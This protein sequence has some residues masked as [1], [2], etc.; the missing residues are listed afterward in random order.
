MESDFE[1]AAPLL[2]IDNSIITLIIISEEVDMFKYHIIF[3]IFSIVTLCDPVYARRLDPKINESIMWFDSLNVR[4]VSNWP[5]GPSRAVACDPGR[6]LVFCGSGGGVYV[7]DISTPASPIKV[8]EGIRSRSI[9][10]DLYYE[11]NT[12]RLYIADGWDCRNEIWDLTDPSN[13]IRL[14]SWDTQYFAW[15]ITVDD[16]FAYVADGEAGIRIINVADPLNPYEVGFC[17]TIGYLQSGLDAVDTMLYAMDGRLRIFNVAQ[18]ASPYVAGYYDISC[19]DVA[20]IDTVAFVCCAANGFRIFNVANPANIQ[21]LGIDPNYCSHLALLDTFAY[22]RGGPSTAAIINIADIMNPYVVGQCNIPNTEMKDIAIIGTSLCIPTFLSGL[23]IVDVQNPTNPT[24]IT[25]FPLPDFANNVVLHDDYAYVGDL[26]AGLRILDI[27]NP[28]NS[29]EVGYYQT[30]AWTYEVEVYDSLAYVCSGDSGL[31]II[32]VADPANPFEVGYCETSDL[33]YSVEIVDTI[34][35][36]AADDYGLRVINISDPANPYKISYFD[37]PGWAFWVDVA[38]SYAYVA[39]CGSGLRIINISDPN[40]PYEEGFYLTPGP[41]MGVA[42]ADSFAYVA[43]ETEGLRIINVA[44]PANPHEVAYIYTDGWPEGVEVFDSLVIVGAWHGGLRV[45]NV[46]DPLNPYECGYYGT[47]GKAVWATMR[48]DLI[49]VATGWTGL[50]IYELLQTGVEEDKGKC[51]NWQ[52]QLVQNPVRGRYIHIQLNIEQ[53]SNAC[54][55][56]YNTVGQ[57]AQSIPLN[58][59]ATGKHSLKIPITN[60]PNGIYFLRL[61][62][63]DYSE[64]KKILLIR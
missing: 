8:S 10:H 40:S 24:E 16:T 37:T 13:P 43:N 41:A 53:N 63:E 35:Y 4:F 55:T 48:D 2:H 47:P 14:G 3:V 60:L 11:Q 17:D 12:Q 61:H 42:V 9:V 27:S 51:C 46:S 50:Q 33:A 28:E 18:P 44:D 36:V 52:L 20:V 29:F 62:T 5:F 34:A 54:L 25:H 1:S 31:R 6:D 49:Y 32:N 30:P 26:S 58:S 45:I 59:F 64:T 39:D 15:R 57:M 22:V 19:S 23:R 56:I 38:G 7:I 21:V